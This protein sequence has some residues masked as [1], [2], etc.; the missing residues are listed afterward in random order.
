MSDFDIATVVPVPTPMFEDFAGRR[1]ILGEIMR[2]VMLT[3]LRDSER[4]WTARSFGEDWHHAAR[5][6]WLL[7]TGHVEPRWDRRYTEDDF[8]TCERTCPVHGD[9]D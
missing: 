9:D 8:C 4:E 6:R 1:P 5:E 3:E 7:E 2:R